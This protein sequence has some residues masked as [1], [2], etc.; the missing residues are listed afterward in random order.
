MHKA[1]DHEKCYNT[2]IPCIWQTVLNTFLCTS[3]KCF[4]ATRSLYSPLQT[5]MEQSVVY[6]YLIQVQCSQSYKANRANV[7]FT[8]PNHMNI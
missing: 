4:L 5:C 7:I 2:R 6:L 8:Q 3:D 1:E